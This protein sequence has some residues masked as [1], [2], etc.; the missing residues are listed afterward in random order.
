MWFMDCLHLCGYD[1]HDDADRCRMRQRE[2][3]MLSRAGLNNPYGRGGELDPICLTTRR[4]T[5]RSSRLQLEGLAM[6]GMSLTW[7]FVLGLPVLALHVVS[8]ALTKALQSHSRSLLEAH[9][10]ARGRPERVDLWNIGPK[11][12]SERPRRWPF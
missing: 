7:M 12:R 10:E 1:D 4:T 11:E 8:I 2:D 9:C 5:P 6:D 3:E